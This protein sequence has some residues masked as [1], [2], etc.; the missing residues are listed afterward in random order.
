MDRAGDWYSSF[1]EVP[2]RLHTQIAASMFPPSAEEANNL[3]LERRQVKIFVLD[4]QEM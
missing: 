4:F 3:H 1:S 2:E